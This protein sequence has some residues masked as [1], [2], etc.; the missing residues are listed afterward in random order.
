MEADKKLVADAANGHRDAFDELVRRYRPRVLRTA[1]LLTRN[2][3]D[4][5]DLVQETFVRAFRAIQHFRGDSTFQTWLERIAR[6]VVKSHL[7]MRARVH[8]MRCMA[9]EGPDAQWTLEQ[10]PSS[11]NVEIAF[12]QRCMID[13][14]LATLTEDSRLLITLRDIHG[15]EYREI[16]AMIGVPLGTVESRLFRA[17]RQLR[18][19]LQPLRNGAPGWQ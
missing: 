2:D 13:R 8:R 12:V 15:L 6:N 1:R 19:L 10:L 4:T 7:M 3:A 18:P 5:E 9:D 16:S 11:E 14:A 17:R